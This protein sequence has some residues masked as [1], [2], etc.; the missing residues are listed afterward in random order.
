MDLAGQ[1]T[2]GPV[3][4]RL[5]TEGSGMWLTLLV[6]LAVPASDSRSGL[7]TADGR[8]RTT[9]AADGSPSFEK[10]YLDQRTHVYHYCLLQVRNP[11]EAEDLAAEVFARAYVAYERVRDERTR[12]AWLFAIARHAV[13][14]HRR[15]SHRWTGVFERLTRSTQPSSDIEEMVAIREELRR[16]IRALAT[17]SERDRQF[18]ALRFGADLPFA[19]V[20]ATMAVSEHAATVGTYRAL[21]R[22]RERF[23]AMP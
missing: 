14:D 16:A 8:P 10:L 1:S 13:V 17:L 9:P 23:E 12:I 22:L 21:A 15:R 19:A 2:A 3:S 18:V 11:A 4:V 5:A 7:P 6:R 20:A